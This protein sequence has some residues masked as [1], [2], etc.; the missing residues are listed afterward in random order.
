MT[1]AFDFEFTSNKP[2]P[3]TPHPTNNI[4]TWS[5]DFEPTRNPLDDNNNDLIS[6][7]NY[8]NSLQK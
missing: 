1:D 2:K 6:D 5:I 8:N 7:N 3:D 4:Q